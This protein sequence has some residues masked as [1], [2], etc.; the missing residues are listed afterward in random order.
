MDV[1]AKSN[2]SEDSEK[3]SAAHEREK[4]KKCLGACLEQGRHFSPFVASADGLLGEE[5][6]ILWSRI[7][8]E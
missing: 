7:Q 2:R 8:R 1:D 5:A 4:K 6:K 3:V